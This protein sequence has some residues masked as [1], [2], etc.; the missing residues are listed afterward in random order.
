MVREPGLHAGFPCG[1]G[2]GASPL[3]GGVFYTPRVM[4][5][6]L[7]QLLREVRRCEICAAHL[8]FGPRPV[9]AAGATARILIVGQAPGRRV[10]QSGVPWDDPS[11]NRLREW[12]GVTEEEFY[13]ADR[14]A[15]I[16]MGFCYPG[17]GPSGDL[18]PRPECA[19]T[20]HERLLQLLPSVQLTLLLS[21][22][23][24]AR[25]LER[26]KK[27]SLTATVKA[28][29]EFRPRYIPL[30]HPSPRNNIWLRKNPWFADDVLP[31]LRRRVRRILRAG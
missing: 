19:D 27:S 21:R 6:C 3:E 31:Y 17:S 23:A 12:M 8:P 10:H 26:D 20:W 7:K 1:T 16:P 18:P 25:Y 29:R 11:G 24:Q 13:D 22:Y 30:P 14:I 4:D 28:W 5:T 2:F 9:L 15:L